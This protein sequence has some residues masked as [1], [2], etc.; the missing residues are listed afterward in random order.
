MSEAVIYDVL[1]DRHKDIYYFDV[2]ARND[3]GDVLRSQ[4]VEVGLV[5]ALTVAS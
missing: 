3:S 5:R 4:F 2:M 1:P